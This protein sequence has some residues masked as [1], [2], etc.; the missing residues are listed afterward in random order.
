MKRAVIAAVLAL[1]VAVVA[2]EAWAQD[3]SGTVKVIQ[4]KERVMTLDDGTKLFW[5]ETQTMSP[6]IKPG[7]KVKATYEQGQ[8]GKYLLKEIEVVK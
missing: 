5:T 1:L 8:D 2:G 3:V 6:E 7:A 4:I